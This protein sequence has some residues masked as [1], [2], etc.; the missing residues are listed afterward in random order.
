MPAE[1]NG[2]RIHAAQPTVVIA[3]KEDVTTAL[4]KG[5]KLAEAV[6]KKQGQ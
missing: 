6:A 2:A 3:G 1:Q 5:Q 4:D